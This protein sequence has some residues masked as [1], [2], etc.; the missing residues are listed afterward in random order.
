MFPIV[1]PIPQENKLYDGKDPIVGAFVED[2]PELR[3]K[4]LFIPT[5]VILCHDGYSWVNC[6]NRWQLGSRR[7]RV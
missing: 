6:L 5:Q 7:E 2:A 1:I 3:V 4:M